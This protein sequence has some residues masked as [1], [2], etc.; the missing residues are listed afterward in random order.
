MIAFLPPNTHI[1][2]ASK[3]SI[4]RPSCYAQFASI[5]NDIYDRFDSASS[6]KERIDF[7]GDQSK[8]EAY[9]LMTIERTL[10]PVAKKEGLNIDRDLFEFGTDS[11]QATRIRNSIMKEVQL[12]GVTLGQN[13]VYECGCVRR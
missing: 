1:P 11:L 5:I 10:G 8:L 9:L 4:L 3:L 13:V 6:G 2:V 12:N 7:C